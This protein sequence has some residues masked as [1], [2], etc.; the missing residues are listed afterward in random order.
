M[1]LLFFYPP[2][3]FFILGCFTSPEN[4]LALQI[5]HILIPHFYFPLF[6]VSLYSEY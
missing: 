1:D 5:S 4:L 6:P 2:R 3:S